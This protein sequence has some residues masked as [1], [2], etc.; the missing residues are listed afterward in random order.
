MSEGGYR[1][2]HQL[3]HIKA[4]CGMFSRKCAMCQEHMTVQIFCSSKS[5]REDDGIKISWFEI[6]QSWDVSPCNTCRLHQDIPTKQKLS[7]INKILSILGFNCKRKRKRVKIYSFP[8]LHLCLCSQR[9]K[10]LNSVRNFGE[11]QTD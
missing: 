5:T 11:E 9:S 7:I 3:C 4:L 6:G 1:F 10:N 2:Y 8:R